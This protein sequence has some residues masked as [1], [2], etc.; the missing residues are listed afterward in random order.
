MRAI[1]KLRFRR[2]YGLDMPLEWNKC[3]FYMSVRE[4]LELLAWIVRVS[5]LQPLNCEY[6]D[7]AK[8]ALIEC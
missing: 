6:H 3:K 8:P 7:K 1:Y 5:I 4:L 2:V